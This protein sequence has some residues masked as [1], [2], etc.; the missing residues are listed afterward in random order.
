MNLED[1][2]KSEYF[3]SPIM[4]YGMKITH[5]PT[6]LSVQ[7]NCKH[8][9]SKLAM[10]R[11]LIDTLGI[12]VAQAESQDASLIRKSRAERENDELRSRLARL[13][14]A[15]AGSSPLQNKAVQAG[16]EDRKGP[17][18]RKERHTARGKKGGAWTPERRAAAAA[19]MK[20]RQAKKYGR[21]EPEPTIDT[22][23]GEM[24]QEEFIKRALRP[25]TDR[26]QP[27]PKAHQSHGTTV[28]KVSE[29]SLAKGFRP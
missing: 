10:E 26:P 22:P 11:V 16:A 24:T 28:V 23:Q 9:Q 12:F 19:R 3:D 17:G 6:G 13:E 25:G 5:M 4:P 7:G 14:A 21:K 8:E 18:T 15:L 29:E 2:T 27:L 1:I 20:E